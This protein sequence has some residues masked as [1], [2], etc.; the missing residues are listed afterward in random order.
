M[1]F[2]QIHSRLRKMSS[3]KFTRGIDLAG[4]SGNI[5]DG[6]G[7]SI[8]LMGDVDNKRFFLGF[9]LLPEL[10]SGDVGG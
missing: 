5:Y 9:L 8:V 3:G 7:G 1:F 2:R 6:A 10:I 4:V